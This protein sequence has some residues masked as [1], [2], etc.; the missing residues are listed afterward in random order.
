M[1][2]IKNAL[3]ASVVLVLSS[4]VFAAD[5]HQASRVIQTADMSSKTAAYE[6]A[7]DKLNTM[8]NDSAIELNKELGY[9]ST[10]AN[11]VSLNAGAYITVAEKMGSNGEIMYTGLV[12]VSASF[13]AVN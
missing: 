6:L 11:S 1:K 13:T 9:V 3:I 12:N 5:T 4:Q 2:M 10:I 7:L 8:Q